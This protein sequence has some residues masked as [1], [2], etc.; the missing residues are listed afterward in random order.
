MLPCGHCKSLAPVYEELADAFAKEDGVIIAKVDADAHKDLGKKYGVTGFPTLKWFPK[1]T[2]SPEDYS[3]GRDLESL[4]SFVSSKTGLKA[5]LKKPPPTAVRVLDNSEDFYSVVGDKN[6]LVEFYAPWCGHCKNLAPTYEKV[7][8]AFAN[9]PNCVDVAEKYE[10]S[11]YPTI[12]FFQSGSKEAVTY[13]GG[14]TEADFISF[15]NDKCGTERVPG[16]GLKATAGVLPAFD[17][18]VAKFMTNKSARQ[19]ALEDAKKVSF[20]QFSKYAKFYVKVM[21][22]VIKDGDSYIAKETGRLEKIIA[23]GTTTA[24]KKDDFEIRKNILNIFA[25]AGAKEVESDTTE[26]DEL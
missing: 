14:R 5:A 11:G 1:D 20:K 18:A 2:T 25:A 26:K 6:I 15:L 16:G 19:A 17:A 3:S 8:Q 4:A 9:E 12:K 13:E 10:V 24:A 23:S 7:A 21:E 22:K